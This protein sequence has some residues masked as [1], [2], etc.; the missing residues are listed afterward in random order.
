VEQKHQPRNL[1]PSSSLVRLRPSLDNIYCLGRASQGNSYYK[2]ASYRR[3]FAY[4]FL[5]VSIFFRVHDSTIVQA[6]HKCRRKRHPEDNLIDRL[7]SRRFATTEPRTARFKAIRGC[8][9]AVA[10]AGQEAEA[11]QGIKTMSIPTYRMPLE[12]MGRL[13]D[14]CMANVPHLFRFDSS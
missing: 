1:N 4:F 7:V 6:N 8:I 3:M 2:T 11:L 5:F 13:R 9:G 12:R 14:K 10:R